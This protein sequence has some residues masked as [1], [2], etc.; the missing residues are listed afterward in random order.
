[1]RLPQPLLESPLFQFERLADL[2]R[3]IGEFGNEEEI[4]EIHR[5]LDLGLP[6]VA[7]SQTLA[8]LLGINPGLVWSFINRPHRHYRQFTIPKGR[9][10]RVIHAPR[11][12]LKIPQKWL[13]VQLGAKYQPPSHVFGFVPNRSHL[14]A[15]RV[16]LRA[17]WVLSLDIE[18]FFPSTPKVLVEQ[19]LKKMGYGAHGAALI[20]GL[21]CYSGGLAQGAPSSPILS[22][23]CFAPWDD[24]LRE[25]AIAE[26]V[27]LSRYA[28]DI[29]LSGTDEYRDSLKERVLDL[30]NASPWRISEQKV[31]LV[32]E[33]KRRKVH[34]LLVGGGRIRLTKGYRNQLRTYEHLLR[35]GK[36][37]DQKFLQSARG[38]LAF[39]KFAKKELV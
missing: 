25:L 19:T 37:L 15:A 6:P 18:N 38:H 2:E 22:N 12:A 3:A 26:N 35:S 16:H 21:T 5:L 34:G 28:D 33:P 1:M 23:F 36:T 39:A 32:I 30:I 31:S 27:R 7:S 14:D 29:V 24:R 17:R 20:A 10:Q 8:V 13:S 4:T 11:V 9:A